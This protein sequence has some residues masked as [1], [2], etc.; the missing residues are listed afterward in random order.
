MAIPVAALG[1]GQEAYERQAWGE[2][3]EQLLAADNEEALSPA[4][5]ERLA[6]TAYLTGRYVDTQR[7][8][9][10]RTTLT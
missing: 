10:A 2:A 3:Y 1:Q 8:S 4:D 6:M 7:S 9:S 5:L